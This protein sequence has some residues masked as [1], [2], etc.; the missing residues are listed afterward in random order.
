MNASVETVTRAYP[1]RVIG[2]DGKPVDPGLPATLS[3][4]ATQRLEA[5]FRLDPKDRSAKPIAKPETAK[6][7]PAKAGDGK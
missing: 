2:L 3:A 1:V 5:R 6:A 7:D 4:A